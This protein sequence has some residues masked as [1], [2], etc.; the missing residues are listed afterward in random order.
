M[1]SMGS[2]NNNILKN[3]IYSFEWDIILAQIFNSIHE[4]KL[5]MLLVLIMETHCYKP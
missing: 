4:K 2:K 3:L 1:N 5:A